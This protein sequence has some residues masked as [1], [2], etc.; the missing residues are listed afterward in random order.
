M[1]GMRTLGLALLVLAAALTVVS[2]AENV[3]ISTY[4]PSPKGVYQRLSTTDETVLATQGGNVGIGTA[5]PTTNLQV[6]NPA[7][8]PVVVEL[9]AAGGDATLQMQPAGGAAAMHPTGMRIWTLP[10]PA[11]PV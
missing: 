11:G 3:T 7:G 5:T 9:N 2:V 8:G 1:K 4:Y 10:K 6:V